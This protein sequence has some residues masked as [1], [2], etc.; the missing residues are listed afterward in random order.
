MADKALVY[1]HGKGGTASASEQ[2]KSLFPDC[3]IYGFD[4]KSE[5]PWEVR[6]KL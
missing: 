2:F 3:D 1:I 6:C 5:Y 4:Y